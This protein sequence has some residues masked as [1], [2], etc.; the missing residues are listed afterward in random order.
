MRDSN[1]LTRSTEIPVPLEVL[2]PLALILT[3]TALTA[4]VAEAADA[5]FSSDPSPDPTIPVAAK[6]AADAD[7]S[8]PK[9]SLSA[10]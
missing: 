3:L 10:R 1:F 5:A 2:D 6:V 4:A 8:P 7:G 9:K